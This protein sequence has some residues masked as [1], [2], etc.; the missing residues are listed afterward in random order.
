MTR[1]NKLVML[2]VLGLVAAMGWQ[3]YAADAESPVKWRKDYAAAEKEAAE[4]GKPMLLYFTASW[5][6]PCQAMKKSTWTDESLAAKLNDG[7]IPVYIDVDEN[8]DVAK[9]YEVSSIPTMIV[10]KDGKEQDKTIGYKSVEQMTAMVEK[11]GAK[12]S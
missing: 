3:A 5:C 8:Q 9:K 7:F 1:S 6:G 11:S 4:S 10:L 2:L 12:K